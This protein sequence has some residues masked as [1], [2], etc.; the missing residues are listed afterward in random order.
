LVLEGDVLVGFADGLGVDSSVGD[1]KLSWVSPKTAGE[2]LGVGDGDFVKIDVGVVLGVGVG[3]LVGVGV[4]VGAGV[5]V[6]VGIDEGE[7]SA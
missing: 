1:C 2:F 4:G 3:D 7:G 6:G 5:G